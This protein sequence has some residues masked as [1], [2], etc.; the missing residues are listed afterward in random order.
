[1]KTLKR[2]FMMVYNRFTSGIK[3]FLSNL[4]FIC[5]EPFELEDSSHI[6]LEF[7]N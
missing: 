3:A 5:Y 7:I 4:I 6:T 1:M 2:I